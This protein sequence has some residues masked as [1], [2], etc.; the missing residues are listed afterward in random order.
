MQMKHNTFCT[1]EILD[2]FVTIQVQ[3]HCDRLQLKY[4]HT[5]QFFLKLET[6]FYLKG[7]KLENTCLYCIS[8]MY[9]SRIK[10]FFTNSRL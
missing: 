3:S 9:A 10:H 4:C 7:V 6:Q 8:V 1:Q 2:K 5:M